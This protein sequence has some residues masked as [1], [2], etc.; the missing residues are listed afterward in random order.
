MNGIS[1]LKQINCLRCF[2]KRYQNYKNSGIRFMQKKAGERLLMFVLTG[3]RK[4]WRALQNVQGPSFGLQECHV[5][6]H[7]KTS[8]IFMKKIR[9]AIW[10]GGPFQKRT[11]SM[12]NMSGK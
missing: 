6:L 4:N 12:M 7:R 9:S 5:P 8:L 11:A 2:L 1:G 3:H 10:S